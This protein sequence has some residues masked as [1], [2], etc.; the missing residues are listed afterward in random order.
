MPMSLQASMTALKESRDVRPSIP[1]SRVRL[2]DIE[3]L[4]ERDLEWLESEARRVVSD[5]VAPATE[6][7]AHLVEK[8]GKRVR[9]M[10]VLLSAACFGGIQE[11]T[12]PMALAVELL[13]SATLLHDD[14][15]D[16]GTQRR[17]VATSRLLWGNA[18][19]VLGG[20]LLLV[21]ALKLTEE[22][23]P[24][25]LPE[26]IGTLRLLV[27]GE[28][29]QLKGRSDLDL[30]EV[31][32]Q[33]ILRGKTASLFELAARVGARLGGA[34]APQE[35]ALA[36][37]GQDLG[38]AFQ[39]VDDLLDYVGTS[40][41]KTLVADLREGKVTLPL[42]LASLQHP[43]LVEAV[44]AIHRGDEVDVEALRQ[45]VA[46][47]PACD[48]VRRRARA[49]TSRAIERLEQTVMPCAAREMLVS[50]AGELASRVR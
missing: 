33:E 18:M 24:S 7:A 26:L 35:E 41:G 1:Q 20:D 40:S 9:P 36:S 39:L 34:A 11:G 2:E 50:I 45:A 48:E 16:E 3:V 31:T 42:V 46:T 6:A 28:V 27:D 10:L 25:A 19:S 17:G 47:S 43:E 13:H 32:Y 22:A 49:H 4:V 37:V 8:G 44:R 30:S 5:G 38:M 21:H 29:R 14:V 12:R 23:L 15:V